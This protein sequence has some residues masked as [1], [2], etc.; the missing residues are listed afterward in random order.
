[1][2]LLFSADLHLGKPFTTTKAR[3]SQHLDCIEQAF[4]NCVEYAITN[5]ADAVLF[6]GDV[7]DLDCNML[8]A[9]L[10][11]VE[12][13][14]KL[15]ENG[16]AVFII[17]GN[18]DPLNGA[19]WKGLPEGCYCYGPEPSCHR[20]TTA[21]GQTLSVTGCS[22]SSKAITKNLALT[23]PAAR[24]ADVKVAMLH[25]NV[26]GTTDHENYAP[27]QLNDLLCKGYDIWHLGHVHSYKLLNP[28]TPAV[29][30]TGSLQG[31]SIR[32]TGAHGA[33]WVDTDNGSW[34]PQFVPLDTVR[35]CSTEVDL[36]S[37]QTEADMLAKFDA[38]RRN[39]IQTTVPVIARVTLTGRTPMN[40]ELQRSGLNE[41]FS[42]DDE[43]LI[44]ESIRDNTLPVVDPEQYAESESVSGEVVRLSRQWA[45]DP[46]KVA[47]LTKELN[48]VIS[49]YHY[50]LSDDDVR[51]A[52][53]DA[54]VDAL[55]VLCGEG[56]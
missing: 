48:E 7:V 23:Y 52:L 45:E 25:C 11:F 3:G 18:H 53:I 47:Q 38:L 32:E 20:I 28:S 22:H 24:E 29:F 30:Y 40:A 17:N 31:L 50:L 46:D 33:V 44:V 39:L 6:A 12:Y 26:G 8:H 10:K 21:S 56:E 54:G 43:N 27:C 34:R 4:G 49:K 35:W 37:V 5:K 2:R 14:R 42:I 41:L 15:V 36:T 55:S 51:R 13:A 1:M 19:E 16:I 9:R